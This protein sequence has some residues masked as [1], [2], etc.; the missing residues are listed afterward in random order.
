MSVCSVVAQEKR[1]DVSPGLYEIQLGK[2]FEPVQKLFGTVTEKDVKTGRDYSVLLDPEGTEYAELLGGKV[3]KLEV[4]IENG[5]IR[6]IIVIYGKKVKWLVVKKNAGELYGMAEC[7]DSEQNNVPA[8]CSWEGERY[9]L[10]L[11]TRE[12]GY[13]KATFSLR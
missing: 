12:S 10:Y 4:Y 3:Q 6:E 13:F 11:Y 5:L 9:S 7:T 8:Y 2:P 1:I